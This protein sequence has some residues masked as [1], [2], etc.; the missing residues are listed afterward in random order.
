MGVVNYIKKKIKREAELVVVEESREEEAK[1][2]FCGLQPTSKQI[3][4]KNQSISVEEDTS[5]VHILV[6][7]ESGLDEDTLANEEI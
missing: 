1:G 6:Q 3:E 2:S 5:K 4:E 7:N